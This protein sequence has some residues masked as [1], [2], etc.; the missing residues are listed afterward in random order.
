MKILIAAMSYFI[1]AIPSGYVIVRLA[2]KKDIREYGS[3][4]TGATNVLRVRGWRLAIPVALADVL[5]GFLPAFIALRAFQDATLAFICASLAVIGHCF[6]V[7]IGF[8][9]GKGVATAAG[10]MFAIAPGPTFLCLGIFLLVIG[11]TGFV[12]LGSILAVLAFPVS[13]AIWREPGVHILLSLPMLFVILVRHAGNIRRLLQ[14]QER[15][16]GQ[17][18]GAKS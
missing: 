3:R 2:A 16:F 4:S 5:K 13:A 9:G 6:P 14:G 1:G 12:S 18:A 11:L 8:R 7:Y 15:K 10:A 17:K